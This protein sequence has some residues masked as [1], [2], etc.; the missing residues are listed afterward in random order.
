MTGVK[1]VVTCCPGSTSSWLTTWRQLWSLFLPCLRTWNSLLII[2]PILGY[3]LKQQFSG[4]PSQLSSDPWG[5]VFIF[6]NCFPEMPCWLAW[7]SGVQLLEIVTEFLWFILR[8]EECNVVCCQLWLG[9]RQ[10]QWIPITCTEFDFI[11]WMT[12]YH[13]YDR[14]DYYSLISN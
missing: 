8:F 13:D 10:T 11:E 14:I 2:F 1:C 7:E 3:L 12:Y 5:K 4:I 6:D 9:L